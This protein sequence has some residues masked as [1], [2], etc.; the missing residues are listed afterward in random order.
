[1]KY[2]DINRLTARILDAKK[3]LVGCEIPYYAGTDLAQALAE[4]R[5]M[6]LTCTTPHGSAFLLKTPEVGNSIILEIK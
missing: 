3:R 2:E 1:M 5:E 6:V 4:L